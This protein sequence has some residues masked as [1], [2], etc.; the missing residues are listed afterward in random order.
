MTR[1]DATPVL[2]APVL[3]G[4]PRRLRDPGGILQADAAAMA[5]ARAAQTAA[6]VVPPAISQEAQKAA[7]QR[8]YEA[9]LARGQE[10]ARREVAARLARLDQI[11]ESLA[12]KRDDLLEVLEEDVV[13]LAVEMAG[14]II[15]EQARRADFPQQ[16]IQRVLQERNSSQV[17]AVRLAPSDLE[18]LQREGVVPPALPGNA[19]LRADPQVQLGGCI[20]DT[21][22]GSLDA[23]LERQLEQLRA[24]LL[25]ARAERMLHAPAAAS[26]AAKAADAP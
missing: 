7:E 5:A 8:G 20:V 19:E 11:L 14:A 18:F 16:L 15:G 13:E 9:G 26:T 3:G 17:L 22:R 1:D 12:R 4:E 23:R 10:S 24:A 2:R 6:Q 21:A 25:D